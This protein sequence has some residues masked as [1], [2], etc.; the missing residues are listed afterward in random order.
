MDLNNIYGED[1]TQP[2]VASFRLAMEW[3]LFKALI[4]LET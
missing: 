3:Q 2:L 4:S 1:Y